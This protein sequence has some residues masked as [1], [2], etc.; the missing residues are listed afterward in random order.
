MNNIFSFRKFYRA[1]KNALRGIKEA[2][3]EQSFR[4]LFLIAVFVTFCLFYFPFGSLERAVLI[5][6][7]V[8]VLSLELINSQI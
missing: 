1:F 2:F 5:L 4:I 3:I 6:V 8:L 7:V